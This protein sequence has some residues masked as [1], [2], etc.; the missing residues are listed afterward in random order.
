MKP[1]IAPRDGT[2][3][4]FAH[5]GAAVIAPE[6]TIGAFTLAVEL[7][8]DGIA[9]EAWATADGHAVLDRNGHVGRRLRRQRFGA[10]DRT[11]VAE[12]VPSIDDVYDL[13]GASVD[14]MIDVRDKAAFGPIVAAAQR[15]GEH[16][17]R[18][19]WLRHGDVDVLTEWRRNTAAKLVLV[20]SAGRR[21]APEPLANELRERGIDGLS[22]PHGAWD[23]GLIALVHRF[24][25]FALATDLVHEREMAKLLDV[26]IDGIA[27]AHVDRMIAVAAQ[28]T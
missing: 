27:S 26:G 3:R 12:H 1:R 9:T 11:D 18:R 25:R 17:D 6:N 20:R 15:T 16:A 19:L 23:G 13:F 21:G 2:T 24:D 14:L 10:L 4:L 22:L 8:A 5:R 28:F 7:G